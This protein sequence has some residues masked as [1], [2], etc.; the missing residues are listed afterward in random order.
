MVHDPNR[1]Q[2]LSIEASPLVTIGVEGREQEEIQKEQE[3]EAES[4]GLGSNRDR[5]RDQR[6]RGAPSGAETEY[7]IQL[8]HSQERTSESQD[9]SEGAQRSGRPQRGL[10]YPRVD[11]SN[12]GAEG[13]QKASKN[14]IPKPMSV[15]IIWN[16]AQINVYFI[17][18]FFDFFPFYIIILAKK[19]SPE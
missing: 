13:I 5:G 17:L 7:F 15:R 8:A 11:F 9:P 4:R 10:L 2:Y 14:K 12:T 16:Q 19:R 1:K 3:K 18:I 6:A